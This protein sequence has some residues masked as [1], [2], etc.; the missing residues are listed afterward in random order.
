MHTALEIASYIINKCIDMERPVSNLQL[1]K[2]LYYVQGEYINSTNGEVLF[3]DTMEAWQYG[4]VIP[5]VYYN[6][7]RY[8]SS[9]IIVKQNDVE[10][11]QFEM[12][13][14]DPVIKDKSLCSAWTL[15]EKTH[16]EAPWINSYE[17]GKKNEITTECLRKYFAKM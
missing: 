3:T 2:I 7:N 10:L 15:V 5:N 4:P 12:D 11:E 1:Q 14:I 8:S 16:S 17:E 13:I 6:Y 9:S